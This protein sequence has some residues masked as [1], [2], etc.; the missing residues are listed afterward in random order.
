ML[1]STN[2]QFFVDGMRSK[3]DLI[4]IDS[5]PVLPISD[6]LILSRLADFS[7]FVLRG[8]HTPRAAALGA[9][10]KLRSAG[11]RLGA[12]VLTRADSRSCYGYTYGGTGRFRDE[13]QAH[14]SD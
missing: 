3:Y 14:Y 8:D 5:P 9:L 12:I 2:M 11:V 4:L 13:I 10:R 7:L 6:A 1:N